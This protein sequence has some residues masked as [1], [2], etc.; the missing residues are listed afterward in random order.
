MEMEFVQIND[1]QVKSLA[2]DDMNQQLHVRYQN[3]E[4]LVYYGVKKADYVALQ[5]TAD[6]AGFI[7][8]KIALDY[9]SERMN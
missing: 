6:T 4:Y 3:G 1:Q 5:G 2:Y 7:D 8:S 9:R